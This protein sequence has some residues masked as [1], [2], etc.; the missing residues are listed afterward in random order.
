MAR[1][2][3]DDM[4]A[5]DTRVL[6]LANMCGWSKRETR[7][8]LED[9]WSLCYDRVAP[10]LPAADIEVTARGDAISP[11]TLTGTFV[12][13]LIEVGL[14]RPAVKADRIHTTRDGKKVPWLDQQW[15][16]KLYLNG[17]GERVG[18]LLGKKRGGAQG[19][20]KSG[21]SRRSRG[22]A[23]SKQ[24]RSTVEAQSK[25]TFTPAEA[26]GNPSVP[27]LV[28]DPV[29]DV[30]S[31]S[32]V[33]VLPDPAPAHTQRPQLAVVPPH[34]HPETTE[35]ANQLWKAACASYADL[36]ACG[37]DSQQPVVWS[38]TPSTRS[39]EWKRC[40]ERVDELLDTRTAVDAIAAGEHRIAVAAAEARV[41]RTTEFFAPLRMWHEV[42]FPTA[43]AQN[44]ERIRAAPGVRP[45]PTA[46][47]LA[48][49]AE[50]EEQE[51]KRQETP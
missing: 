9:I 11:P 8:C 43:L 44:P 14:A 42:S 30:P 28:P 31:A 36:R 10:Y 48:E 39:E 2:S 22:E 38:G 12:D 3:I 46:L 16:G 5:R 17:T 41:K 37:I 29:P 45:G 4:F 47:A 49:L 40:C 21:E 50:L 1:M 27:D 35:V 34:R 15:E 7:A 18:Y 19:G 23:R 13:A 24:G 33:S 25:L 20:V 32:A 51:R 26:P 6:R